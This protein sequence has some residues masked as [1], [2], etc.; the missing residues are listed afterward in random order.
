VGR[1]TAGYGTNE[2]ALDWVPKSKVAGKVGYSLPPGDHPQLAIGHGLSISS[3]SKHKDA[4]YLF[5][6]WLNSEEVSLQRVQLPYTLRDPF[7]TSHYSSPEYLAKWPDANEYLGA[8]KKASETG[9]QDLSLIQTDKYAEVLRQGF[10]RLWAGEDVTTMLDDLAKQWNEI[11]AQ[12][13]LD[14]Q[15]AAYR[16]WASKPGAYPR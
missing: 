1:W 16:A 8:L 4:A 14:K 12:I 5:I 10:G 2:K 6:Q 9:L 15:R 3:R 7:R 11:T 13:G